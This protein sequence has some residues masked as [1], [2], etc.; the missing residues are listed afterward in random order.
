MVKY[1]NNISI[2]NNNSNKLENIMCILCY[3]SNNNINN[4]LNNNNTNNNNN[5]IQNKQSEK[6]LLNYKTLEDDLNK[7]L[8]LKLNFKFEDKNNL[9]LDYEE[10]YFDVNKR[11]FLALPSKPSVKKEIDDFD[12]LLF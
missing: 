9:K 11:N 6:K 3:K 7:N 2:Q 8:N 10:E 1:Y 5:I 12:E 4:N